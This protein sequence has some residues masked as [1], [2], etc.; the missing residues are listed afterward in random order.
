M[1]KVDKRLELI[2]ATI[3][4]MGRN[5]IDKTTTKAISAE[6]DGINEAYIYRF[7]NSKEQLYKEAFFTIT[8]ELTAKVLALIPVLENAG[9]TIEDR[10]WIFFSGIWDFVLKN[11]DKCRCYLRYYYSPYFKW[12][13]SK[14]HKAFEQTAAK[15]LSLVFNEN[16]DVGLLYSY[17]IGTI[18]NFADKVFN[19][20]IENNEKTAEQIYKLIYSAIEP[21]LQC[22]T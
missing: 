8:N 21:H 1:N 22:Q 10:W 6:A 12:Y 14:E 13:S 11:K 18:L 15:N 4:V 16:T 7:F 2:K 20:E 19:N 3:T 17:I 9:M 5:G